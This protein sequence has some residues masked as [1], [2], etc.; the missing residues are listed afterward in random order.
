MGDTVKNG[1]HFEKMGHTV[2]NGWHLEKWVTLKKLFC[3][4]CENW[5]TIWKWGTRWKMPH[6]WKTR[7]AVK[8]WVTF[9]KRVTLKS[10]CKSENYIWKI[11]RWIDQQE[12]SVG[13]RKHLG[14]RQESNLWP[15]EHLFYPPPSPSRSPLPT[16][17][18]FLLIA[19]VLFARPHSELTCSIST[20]KRKGNGC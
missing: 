10:H 5:V 4:Q 11:Q 19:G 15:P 3:S 18:Q 16:S 13:Q 12:T 2:K 7:H 14:S 20:W 8:K 17:P 9:G 6:T 1:S